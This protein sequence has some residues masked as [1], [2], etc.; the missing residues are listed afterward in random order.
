[1]IT[2]TVKYKRLGL[3]SC[4]KKLKK[5][6]GDGLVEN[7]IS[8]FF[9]LEDETRIELPVVLIFTFSKGRFYGIK[10]RMEEEARQPISLKKG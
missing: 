10:E 3:F 7:N 1:M 2:Y 8:R 4:W 6:K 5:V 9:I